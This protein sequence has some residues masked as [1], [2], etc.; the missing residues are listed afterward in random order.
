MSGHTIRDPAVTMPSPYLPAVSPPDSGAV[1]RI[2]ASLRIVG[3]DVDPD[4]ITAQLGISP[5]FAARNGEEIWSRGVTLT[6]R[7]GVWSYSLTERAGSGDE[8]DDAIMRLLARFPVDEAIWSALAAAHA[9]G[10]AC[11]LHLTDANQGTDLRPSTLQALAAR[12]LGLSL[13]IYSA[14]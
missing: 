3:D 6:Q 12:H 14:A 13:D 11:G 8:L 10:V 9:V 5:T 1:G 7:H 4:T 2:T